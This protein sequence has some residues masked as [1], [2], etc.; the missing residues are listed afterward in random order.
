M[1]SNDRI[2]FSPSKLP[3]LATVKRFDLNE[4]HIIKCQSFGRAG[5]ISILAIE[6]S[7]HAYFTLTGCD[8]LRPIETRNKIQIA[9]STELL[10]MTAH[11]KVGT[12]LRYRSFLT[13]KFFSEVSHRANVSF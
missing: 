4:A 8:L 9:C 5:A 2:E 3:S 6:L 12:P 7:S 11:Q 13:L 1:T 10:R